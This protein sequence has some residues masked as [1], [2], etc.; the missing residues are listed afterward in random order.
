MGNWRLSGNEQSLLQ[1]G[2]RELTELM[3]QKPIRMWVLDDT[4][5][6]I[7]ALDPLHHLFWDP[8]LSL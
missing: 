5:T 1:K 7:D 3:L 2:L 8:G 6:E 4:T